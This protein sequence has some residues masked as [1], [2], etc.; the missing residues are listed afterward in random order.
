MILTGKIGDMN[1]WEFVLALFLVQLIVALLIAGVN[2]LLSK[3]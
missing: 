2:A 3:N 1:V